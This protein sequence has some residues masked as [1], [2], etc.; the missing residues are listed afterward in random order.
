MKKSDIEKIREIIRE[1]LTI[2]GVTVER[3]N[4]DG[5]I[6]RKTIDLYL[7]EWLAAEI[8]SLAG[9]LRGV[10]ET[11]D[12]SK[13]NSAKVIA[14]FGQLASV[15]EGSINSLNEEVKKINSTEAELLEIE[16]NS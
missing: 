15:L 11:A 5:L 12:H 14:A 6:E 3:M 10:Q 4:S 16:S 9:A 8:P 7:P 13:N 2:K 1:E